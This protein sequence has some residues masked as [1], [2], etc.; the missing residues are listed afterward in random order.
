LLTAAPRGREPY[1][2]A[3]AG[4]LAGRKKAFANQIAKARGEN[5]NI[6]KE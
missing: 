4:G 1:F 2:A 6:L 5:F 3:P